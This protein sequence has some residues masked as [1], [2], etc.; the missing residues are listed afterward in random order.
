LGYCYLDQQRRLG[1][2]GTIITGTY[3]GWG[4]PAFLDPDAGDYHICPVSAALDGGVDA[5]VYR[6]IDDQPRP[7]QI[8]DLGTDEYWPPGVL[9]YIY[10]PV[11]L[12]NMP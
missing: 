3:N 1:G 10:L 4:D 11:V 12:R 8:P 7:Y 9:R 5:G 6:D 2:T